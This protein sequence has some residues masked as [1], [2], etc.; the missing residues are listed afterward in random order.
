[1]IDAGDRFPVTHEKLEEFLTRLEAA[2]DTGGFFRA[3][4][5]KPTMLRNIRSMFTRADLTDQEVRTL[6]G[7]VSALSGK[8][9]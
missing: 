8:K 1:M 9:A 2:L 4:D 6:H 7:M 5:L 3:G